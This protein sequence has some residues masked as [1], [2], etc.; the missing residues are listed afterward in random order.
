[1]KQITWHANC[2]NICCQSHKS[3]AA[4]KPAD[5]TGDIFMSHQCFQ[6]GTRRVKKF[7]NGR[8]WIGVVGLCLGILACK[9]TNSGQ[10]SSSLA[11]QDSSLK[12]VPELARPKVEKWKS[13]TICS[14]S[15]YYPLAFAD[16]NPLFI[17]GMG[18]AAGAYE[19][20]SNLCLK[21]DLT[22]G[23]PKEAAKF[24]LYKGDADGKVIIKLNGKCLTE[25]GYQNLAELQDCDAAKAPWQTFRWSLGQGNNSPQ[26][27][28]DDPGYIK[29]GDWDTC[30]DIMHGGR[31][32]DRG[33]K[34]MFNYCKKGGVYNLDAHNQQWYF[35]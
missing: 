22:S 34:M 11:E 2:S 25:T 4:L 29:V 27:R 26:G 30:L 10:T 15:L 23:T 12:Q 33:K 21:A 17:L 19:N 24:D 32:S 1:V 7:L 14:R 8:K 16:F 9:V 35:R 5:K 18:S 3:I 31:Y 13:G 20:D 6:I 28:G